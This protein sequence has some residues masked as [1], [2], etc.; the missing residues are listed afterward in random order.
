MKPPAQKPPDEELLDRIQKGERAAF[1]LLF[2]SYYEELC[3]FVESRI[4]TSEGA[5]DIV[6]NIFLSLW[7][8]REDVEIRSTLRAY[9]FGAARNESISYRERRSVRAQNEEEKM[10]RRKRSRNWSTLSP[11]ENLE[12]EELRQVVQKSIAELPER[13]REVYV[14][15]R[16][17]GLTYKEIAAVMDISPKT[18]D[19]QMVEALKFLRKRVRSRSP[20]ATL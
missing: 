17:H 15:S 1:E 19:H 5:A 4:S 13:R 14:L 2:R 7:R 6:Q 3:A 11:V 8:R 16:Q 12:N 10:E 20:R 18:V 9:L